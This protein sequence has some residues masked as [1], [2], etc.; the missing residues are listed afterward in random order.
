MK[1]FLL[2][3]CEIKQKQTKNKLSTYRSALFGYDFRI[4]F[5]TVYVD[6]NVL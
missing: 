6:F 4:K 3:L 1:K 2:R 5:K